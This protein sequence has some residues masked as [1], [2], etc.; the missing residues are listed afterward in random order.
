MILL[1]YHL[2]VLTGIILELIFNK[3]AQYLQYLDLQCLGLEA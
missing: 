3:S 2:M 1:L